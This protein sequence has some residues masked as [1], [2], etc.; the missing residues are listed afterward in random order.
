VPEYRNI[1]IIF[2]AVI[3]RAFYQPAKE[4]TTRKSKS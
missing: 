4:K 1:I 2:R 3:L